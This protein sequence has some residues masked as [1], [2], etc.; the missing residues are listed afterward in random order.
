MPT[1]TLPKDVQAAQQQSFILR[2]FMYQERSTGLYVAE[3]IDLN[4]IVKARK[5]VKAMREL[6]DAVLGY[7]RVAVEVGEEKNLIP[8]PSPLSHRAHY[9]AIRLASKLSL[10]KHARLFDCKPTAQSRCYA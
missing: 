1:A 8:R 3:C 4:L 9:C 5:D 10:L 6:R 2:C 7:V